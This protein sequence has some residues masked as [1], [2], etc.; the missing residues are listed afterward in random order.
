MGHIKEPKGIDFVVD[1]KPLTKVE[2]DAISAVIAHYKT[3]G[4]KKKQ[5]SRKRNIGPKAPA[6]K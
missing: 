1:P 3:T 5:N 4:K 2:R 6:N